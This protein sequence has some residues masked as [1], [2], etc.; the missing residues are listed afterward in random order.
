MFAASYIFILGKD[1]FGFGVIIKQ[2][3]IKK[4][5]KK[6]ALGNI[7]GRLKINLFLYLNVFLHKIVMKAQI[8]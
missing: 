7:S 1:L 6:R 5:I 8:V 3:K 2:N 4:T